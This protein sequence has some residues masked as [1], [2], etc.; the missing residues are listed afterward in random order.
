MDLELS[1]SVPALVG[2][3]N[4]GCSNQS[5]S[6][7]RLRYEQ[8]KRDSD[9]SNLSVYKARTAIEYWYRLVQSCAAVRIVKWA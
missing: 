1:N 3:Q 6:L 2:L 9:I 8:A 4:P 7:L 5:G